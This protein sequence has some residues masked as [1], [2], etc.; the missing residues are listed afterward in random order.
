MNKSKTRPTG[1]CRWPRR[2]FEITSTWLKKGARSLK[3][4][5]P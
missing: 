2:L 3:L 1:A 5:G 4:S